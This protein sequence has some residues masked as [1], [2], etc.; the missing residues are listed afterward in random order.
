LQ[1]GQADDIRRATRESLRIRD[2]TA[3]LYAPTFRDYMSED[4]HRAAMGD[5]LD[6]ADLAE[7]IGDEYVVLVRGHAFHARTSQ[8]PKT[9]RG[10]VDVTD[11]PDPADLY[12]ASDLAVL[13]YSSLRFDYAVTGKPMIFLVPDLD[14]YEETRGW[15]VDFEATAPG[16]KLTSTSEVAQS[17]LDVADVATEFA[18]AYSRFRSEFLDLEDGH[19]AARLVDAVFVPRGDAPADPTRG[20]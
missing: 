7:A 16:P 17:V 1:S 5:F 20:T 18:T 12:L 11:Y 19:A 8:R 14:R 10:V 2:Q 3:I 9:S 15:L 4:D 13:D 6:T